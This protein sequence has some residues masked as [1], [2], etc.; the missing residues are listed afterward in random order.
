[1]QVHQM[2]FNGVR[3]VLAVVLS[4]LMATLAQAQTG[5]DQRC[6]GFTGQ[7]KGLC[8]AAVSEGCFD[9]VQSQECADLT[10]NWETRCKRCE[11]RL[12]PWQ[13]ECPCGDAMDLFEQFSSQG[14]GVVEIEGCSD[15][16]DFEYLKLSPVR[17]RGDKLELS[18]GDVG[19]P[20][21]SFTLYIA[22][23]V[24][25][26]VSV[27]GLTDAQYGG[28]ADTVSKVIKQILGC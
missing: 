23:G 25:Y 3:I 20:Y 26:D 1:M 15:E 7:A 17:V 5:Q 21:C 27:E 24:S 10:K 11:G 18:A 6:E 16:S 22:N 9:G 2:S 28:C 13:P 12:V 8:T 19:A 14:Y 4:I